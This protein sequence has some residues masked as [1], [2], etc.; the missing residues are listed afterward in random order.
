MG[1]LDLFFSRMRAAVGYKQSFEEKIQAGDI[2]GALG[3]MCL[4]DRKVTKA[5]N[6]YDIEKHEIMQ[7]QDKATFDAKG[8]FK[9]WVKRWRLPLSYPVY[10]NEIALVFI[11]GRPVQWLER[12]KDTKNAFAA[13]NHFIEDTHFNSKIRQ[14]KRLA[15]SETQSA[16]LF[17]TYQNK[18]GKAQCLIKVLAKSLGDDLYYIKDQYDRLLYFARGYYLSEGGGKTTYHVDIFTDDII[19]RCKRGGLGWDIEKEPNY[20]GKKPIILFEQETEWSGANPLIKRQEYMKSRTADVN[21]YMADPALV[22][23]ADVVKGLPEKDTE[24]KLY[25]LSE[26]GQLNYLVPETA[27]ELKKQEREDNER[28]IFR[29]TFTPN[30]DFDTMSKLTNISAKALKQMMI[31]ADIKAQMRKETHDEYLK[32]IANLII[33]IIGKV[34]HVDDVAVRTE[35]ERMKVGHEYQEPFGE[36]I[37]EAITNAIKEVNAGGMSKETLIELNPLVKDKAQEKQRIASEEAIRKQEELEQY[38]RSIFEP[39][40]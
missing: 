26:K 11:Y 9:G 17:H 19:Y 32:R 28:H 18:D 39:T 34:T 31:L 12:T 29:E 37:T 7:R 22:A 5:L 27:D 6:E 23:T 25:V 21:D 35:C 2:S 24:N 20:I 8:N 4:E 40:E 33:T 1:F 38:K 13:F 3:L 16:L 10:I 30:I 36:D 14:A 15:G